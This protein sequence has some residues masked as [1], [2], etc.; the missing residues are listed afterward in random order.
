MRR[1]GAGLK[2]GEMG[3][4]SRIGAGFSGK[5]RNLAKTEKIKGDKDHTFWV[6]CVARMLVVRSQYCWT[7]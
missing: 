5:G 7:K 1:S 4:K 3:N 6:S 2:V